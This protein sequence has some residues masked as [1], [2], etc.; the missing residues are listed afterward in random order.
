[1]K[2]LVLEELMI[3]S[4]REKKAKKI[5]FDS[6]KTLVKGTNQVGKSS[7]IKSIYYTLGATPATM[8]KNWLKAEPISLLQFRLDEGTFKVLRFDKKHFIVVDNDNILH[9]FNFKEFSEYLKN[10]LDFQL[11]INSRQG[12]PEVPPPAYLFLPF[13]VDQDNSWSKNWSSFANLGQYSKWKKPT[14]D[15]HSGVKGNA[16][17]KTKSE[18]D[19]TR[20]SLEETSKEIEALNK[21]LKN[22]NKKLK[23][24]VVSITVEDFNSEIKELLAECEELK[25][26]QNRIKQDLSLLYDKKIQIGAE[27]DLVEKSIKELEKDYNYAL[28]NLEDDV[29]CPTCGANYDNN[30]AER[31]SIAEDEE[32]LEELLVQLRGDHLKIIDK[33]K[34]YDSEFI[35]TKSNYERIQEV[36]NE[37]KSEIK[38]IDIIES[39]GK[40]RVKAI[41]QSEQSDIY[42]K[43]GAAEIKKKAL[44]SKLKEIDKK[45][46]DRKGKIMTLYRSSLSTYLKELNINLDTFSENVF[47]RMDSPINETGSALPRALLAYYFAF[48]KVMSK[49]STSTFC[50]IIIDSPNQQEQDKTNL[51]AILD[52]INKHQPENTQLILGIVDNDENTFDL[53]EKESLLKRDSFEEVFDIMKPLLDQGLFSDLSLF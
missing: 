27:I 31:F 32:R 34:R 44:E 11:I 50:P 28:T 4:L 16:Y 23:E 35:E 43:I 33:I 15:Y 18:L 52:F 30:F 53:D 40:K 20:Q 47:R 10:L 49:Y 37:K 41:F 19:F 22:I 48:L 2:K 14:V 6:K 51:E 7:L 17:Y 12:A 1:M 24:D 38:L 29:D 42:Q 46:E 45:G 39:E 9:S 3:M 8:H 26:K 13:Y 25:V 36:L 5:K 21:I